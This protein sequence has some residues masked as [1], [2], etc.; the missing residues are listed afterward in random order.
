V[1]GKTVARR[2][3]RYHLWR[4][5]PRDNVRA[6]RRLCAVVRGVRSGADMPTGNLVVHLSDMA[7]GL[8]KGRVHTI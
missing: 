3:E 5:L 2:P 1:Q 8:V 6:S 7:G 4:D